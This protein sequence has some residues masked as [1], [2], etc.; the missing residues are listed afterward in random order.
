MLT[1]E[2]FVVLCKLFNMPMK[3][4][5]SVR[6]SKREWACKMMEGN[7]RREAKRREERRKKREDGRW[8]GWA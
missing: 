7:E 1:M 2:L 5:E 6:A 8:I 3:T 4:R